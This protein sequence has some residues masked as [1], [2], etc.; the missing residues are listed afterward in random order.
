MKKYI[1]KNFIAVFLALGMFSMHTLGASVDNLIGGENGVDSIISDTD[2]TTDI[3]LKVVE[4]EHRYAVDL[5]YPAEGFSMTFDGEAVWDV[6]NYEY[7]VNGTAASS[8]SFDCK[9]INHSD[10]EVKVYAHISLADGV[11]LKESVQYGDSSDYLAIPG[12]QV[13]SNNPSSKTMRVQI[14]PS[15]SSSWDAIVKHVLSNITPDGGIYRI[16]SLTVTVEKGA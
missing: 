10:V 6:N 16:G 2:S 5:E 15:T 13:N 14:T 9:F 7:E 12:T 1:I 4:T 3:K 11:E 8:Y